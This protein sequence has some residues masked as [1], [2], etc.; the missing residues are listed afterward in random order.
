MALAIAA[1]GLIAILLTPEIPLSSRR[2][3]QPEPVAEPGEEFLK[4]EEAE[5]PAAS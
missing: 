2:H 3:S 5:E 4:A 1:L